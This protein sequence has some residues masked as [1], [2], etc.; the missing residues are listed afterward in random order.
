MVFNVHRGAYI[1]NC[2]YEYVMSSGIDLRLYEGES[3][4]ITTV[5]RAHCCKKDKTGRLYNNLWS[6]PLPT[7]TNLKM[8]T[9]TSNH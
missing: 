4:F 2:L 9:E 8:I 1:F 6:P 7:N 3:V 5:K